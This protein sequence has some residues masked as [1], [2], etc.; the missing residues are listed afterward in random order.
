MAITE[1]RAHGDWGEAQAAKFLE[2]RGYRIIDTNYRTKRG[3]LD[4]VAWHEQKPGDTTLCFIEVKTRSHDD[5]S[6]ERATGREKQQRLFRAA[7]S[8]CLD[9]AIALDRTAIQFEQVSVYTKPD[10]QPQVRQYVI[11]VE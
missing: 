4:I 2:M 1:K 11:P 7:T 3:E 8:Y 5:G 6:A 9:H 10:G